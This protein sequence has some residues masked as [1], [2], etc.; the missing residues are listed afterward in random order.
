MHQYFLE[1]KKNVMINKIILI[2]FLVPPNFGVCQS[3]TIVINEFETI[4]DLKSGEVL[5]PGKLPRSSADRKYTYYIV[6]SDSN[7][8]FAKYE[9]LIENYI[10]FGYYRK[11]K[12]TINDNQFFYS[13][14]RDLNWIRIGGDS[15]AIQEKHFVNGR[16][17]DQI[18][19]IYVKYI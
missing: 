16:R 19:L 13:W 1:I 15:N 12:F 9:N 5:E 6:E 14:E 7:L 10:E 8:V 3:D 11:L 17:L 4:W 2:L 18:K